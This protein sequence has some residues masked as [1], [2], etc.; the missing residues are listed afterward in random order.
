MF[1]I[2]ER[3]WRRRAAMAGVLLTVI[4]PLLA[5]DGVAGAEVSAGERRLKA[6]ALGVVTIVGMRLGGEPLI[7]ARAGRLLVAVSDPAQGVVVNAEV[8]AKCAGGASAKARTDSRGIASF[9][10]MPVG[11][12]L[13]EVSVPGFRDWRGSFAV[14]AGGEGRLD[15]RLE[16]S[17]PGTKVAVRPKP[18]IRR[19]MDWLSSC[20]RR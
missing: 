6:D 5:Q 4:S 8:A 20:A 10:T 9:T 15:A 13:V 11:D 3:C 7:E 18:V 14:I 17:D 19:F 1:R 12:C 2:T 16:V